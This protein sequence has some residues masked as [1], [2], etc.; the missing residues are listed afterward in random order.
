M[1]SAPPA[2]SGSN[3]V[4][5]LSQQNPAVLLQAAPFW[6]FLLIVLH[7]AQ[8]IGVLEVALKLWHSVSL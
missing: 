3:L 4:C 6:A 8:R 2:L 1:S 7:G 5:A